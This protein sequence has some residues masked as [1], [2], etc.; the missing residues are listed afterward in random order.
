[1]LF[2]FCLFVCFDFTFYGKVVGPLNVLIYHTSRMHSSAISMPDGDV[3]LFGHGSHGQV[4]MKDTNSLVVPVENPLGHP[5]EPQMTAEV[6]SM[7]EIARKKEA[8]GKMDEEVVEGSVDPAPENVAVQVQGSDKEEA[9]F[10]P[11]RE[12]VHLVYAPR[13]VFCGGDQT[14]VLVTVMVRNGHCHY[15]TEFVCV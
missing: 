2:V 3:F 8:E 14:F 4:G 15:Y 5:P 9:P 12:P 6:T 13:H 7:L 1:M 11:A 10:L